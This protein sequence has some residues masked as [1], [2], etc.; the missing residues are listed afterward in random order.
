M[1]HYQKSI[2]VLLAIILH[3]RTMWNQVNFHVTCKLIKI[4][5]IPFVTD[6]L[7]NQKDNA[8]FV[9]VFQTTW[10]RLCVACFAEI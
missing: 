5:Q 1:Y 4:K 9:D 6:N 10:F 8:V 7:A 2:E 3:L